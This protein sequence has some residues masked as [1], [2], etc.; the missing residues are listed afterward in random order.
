MSDAILSEIINLPLE[1]AEYKLFTWDL[2]VRIRAIDKK[3]LGPARGYQPN[4]VQLIVTRG[5]V[6]SYEVG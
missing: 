4:R 6:V 1:D 5:K 2:Q 3:D